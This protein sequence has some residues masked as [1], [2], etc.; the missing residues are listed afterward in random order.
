M[1]NTNP[2]INDTKKGTKQKQIVDNTIKYTEVSKD[3]KIDF[4]KMSPIKNY[5]NA[6]K[7]L[8][9]TDNFNINTTDSFG[10]LNDENQFQVV[11]K[12]KHVNKRRTIT[13][14]AHNVHLRAVSKYSYLY[15]TR[16]EKDITT[17][18]ILTYLTENKFM[19]AV[20]DKMKPKRSEIYSSFRISVPSHRLE[21]LKNP[22]LWSEGALINHFFLETQT[23]SRKIIE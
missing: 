20:C 6:L 5:A 15:V 3:A 23:H 8:R 10:T 22:E 2:S 17:D 18:S 16:L 4:L 9:N 11:Q 1:A 21:S 14:S 13:E 12:R 19:D 7:S